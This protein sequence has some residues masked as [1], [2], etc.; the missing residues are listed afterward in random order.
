MAAWRKLALL[1]CAVWVL[2]DAD[3]SSAADDATPPPAFKPG[4]VYDGA[5]FA[6]LGGGLRSGGTFT[7][8]LNVQVV[9]DGNALFGWPDTLGYVDAHRV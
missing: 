8:N 9:I 3:P 1:G 2:A 5:A 4:I 7:S 6:N